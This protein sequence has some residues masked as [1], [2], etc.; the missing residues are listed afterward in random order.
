MKK[1]PFW[2][3]STEDAP[4][5]THL[6]LPTGPHAVGYQDVMTPGPADEG[7][8]VRFY[9]PSIYPLNETINKSELWP[10]WADDDYL[11][12]FVKFMQAVL[13]KW[14]SWAPRG[15]FMY[16]DQISYIAPL[17]H[18][19][20][21]HVWKFLNGKVH[22][23]ILKNAP[24]S[25]E[26]KWPVIVFSHGMGCNRFAYSRIC[27]DLASH[28]FVVAATEHRDGSGS[29]SFTMEGGTK[30][31]I[32]HRR[33]TDAEKEYT[34]RNQQ[35]HF[36]VAEVKRTMDLV[37]K[38]NNGGDCVNILQEGADY[39]VSM[40]K[41]SMEAS[42]PVLAGHSYGGAT[43]L[44]ALAEDH[45]FKQGLVLDGWL[46]PLKD[47]EISPTQPIVFI[48]TESFMNR[49]NIN[50]MKMFLTGIKDRRMVF[51]KGSVHQNH[52]DA[53]LIFKSG[54]IKKIIGMQSDTDPVLVLDLN[55]KLML[56][57]IWTNLGMELDKDV[58]Q[59]L[60]HHESVLIEASDDGQKSEE[61][62]TESD[63]VKEEITQEN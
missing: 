51:I 17:M 14:P 42:K 22:I 10:I 46:F 8:F 4:P 39:D 49:Q 30:N 9:Y 43:T 19:G 15:E 56:H 40:F 38:L 63:S 29:L 3:K 33:I 1:I 53:P 57:F 6:P 52:I 18:L 61:Y 28:G 36:R 27:T 59:F 47:E 55:D 60:D 44:M 2:R 45:R 20:C 24:I 13:A 25:T 7:I 35:L 23:P 37:L 50:R 12:G 16:I 32:P 21:T 34:V 26:K 41:N 5:P 11:I 48:N 62:L 31:W 54:I 58:V